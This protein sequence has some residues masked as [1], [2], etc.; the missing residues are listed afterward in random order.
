MKVWRNFN[1]YTLLVGKQNS[2]ATVENNLA[3][4]QMLN[5]ELPYD[6]VFTCHIHTQ[7]NSGMNSYVYISVH[8]CPR[9]IIQNS[10]NVKITPVDM[11][12]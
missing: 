7:K 9:G 8:Q 5:I 12:R 4:S 2:A 6:P 3:V 1:L 10:Q 11:N